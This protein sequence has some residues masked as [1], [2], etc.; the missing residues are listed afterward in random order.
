MGLILTKYP[1]LTHK[2]PLISQITSNLQP[3]L[4]AI[5][6]DY[7]GG[8]YPCQQEDCKKI[9]VIQYPFMEKHWNGEQYMQ[10]MEAMELCIRCGHGVCVECFDESTNE[11]AD[12][13]YYICD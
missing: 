3:N 5:C 2:V 13:N 7:V 9:F 10:P 4:V 1:Q 6:L 12:C 11:C 8:V